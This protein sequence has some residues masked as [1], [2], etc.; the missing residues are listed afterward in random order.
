MQHD[1]IWPEMSATLKAAGV[2]N[3]SISLLASTRQ[4]FAHVEIEDEAAWDAIATTEVCQ[5]WW[6][7]MAPL[8][9][10]DAAGRPIAT[11]LRE[12]FFLK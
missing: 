3:Y 4:L 5:R 7:H 9:A 12:V 8:M 11:P 6:R 1:E 10:T 2:H